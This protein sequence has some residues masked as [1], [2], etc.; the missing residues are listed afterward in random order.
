MYALARP[1]PG[2]WNG[3]HKHGSSTSL[4][5]RSPFS[6][7]VDTSTRPAA[8]SDDQMEETKPI[9]AKENF[10]PKSNPTD[11]KGRPDDDEGNE[12]DLFIPA[13]VILSLIGYGMTAA[14]AWV[15]YNLH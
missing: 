7:P 13:M 5:T 4:I 6:R 9:K 8:Q 11:G 1:R 15:E 14:I 12:R 3:E 10:R 2:L